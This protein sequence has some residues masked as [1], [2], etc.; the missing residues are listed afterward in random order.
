MKIKAK[1]SFA[2]ENFSAAQGAVVTVPE[3]VA[4][5]LIQ[6]GYAEPV[7]ETRAKKTNAKA[8]GSKE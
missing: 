4:E 7:E 2:G 6:A 8:K 1:V 3:D 5:D